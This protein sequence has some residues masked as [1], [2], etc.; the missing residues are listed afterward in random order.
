MNICTHL[1]DRHIWPFCVHLF[2][3]INQMDI[4]IM[5]QPLAQVPTI[6]WCG[7]SRISVPH[8]ENMDSRNSYVVKFTGN[9]LFFP[10]YNDRCYNPLGGR[11]EDERQR[12]NSTGIYWT[13]GNK[14]V[15]VLFLYSVISWG[16]LWHTVYILCSVGSIHVCLEN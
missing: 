5:D 12:R 1:A 7:Y 6:T 15:Q 14:Q 4:E 2:Q 3:K 8:E 10:A 11:T 16:L 9:Y 13:E